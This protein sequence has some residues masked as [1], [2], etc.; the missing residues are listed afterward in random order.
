MMADHTKALI[1][2]IF[3]KFSALLSKIIVSWTG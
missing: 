2:S 1:G 3:V